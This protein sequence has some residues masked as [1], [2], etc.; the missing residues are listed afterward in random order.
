V[1]L[2]VNGQTV[3]PEIVKGFAKI[4][5][6]WRKGDTIGVT[7]PMPV[8]RV[9][10]DPRV[11]DDAGRVALE[12]G[13]LVYAAEWPDNGGHA[14]NIVVPDTARL[15]SE[16][17]PDLLDGVEVITGDV[18]AVG[19]RSDGTTRTAPHQ[20]VAIPYYAW[21]TAAWAKCRC[22]CPEGLISRDRPRSRCRI[23]SRPCG[24]RAASRRSGPA[25]TIKTT[26]SRPCTTA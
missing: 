2:T 20:L 26:T 3:T 16:F 12:R 11:R 1:V 13:P 25:T 9:F 17:R 24:H 6:E 19:R 7:L 18:T 14:L 10:A 8:R 23:R 15:T 5:R 4:D 22:G 21:R